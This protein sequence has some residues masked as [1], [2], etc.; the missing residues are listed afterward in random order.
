[1]AAAWQLRALLGQAEVFT[2]VNT[3]QPGAGMQFV[4]AEGGSVNVALDDVTLVRGVVSIDFAEVK[5]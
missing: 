5:P 3:E 4:L 2:L 1:M